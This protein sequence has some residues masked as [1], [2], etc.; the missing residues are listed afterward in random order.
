MGFVYLFCLSFL[1]IRVWKRHRNKEGYRSLYIFPTTL[2]EFDKPIVSDLDLRVALS[3]N[4]RVQRIFRGSDI[5]WH[6]IPTPHSHRLPH[7]WPII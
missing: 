6:H 1:F 2:Q 3:H 5:I 4:F 7:Y